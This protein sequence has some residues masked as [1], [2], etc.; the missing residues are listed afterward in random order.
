MFLERSG[1]REEKRRL[2]KKK[3]K[4]TTGGKI[5]EVKQVLEM[6][7]I[8]RDECWRMPGD[9]D[10]CCPRW[11]TTSSGITCTNTTSYPTVPE[12]GC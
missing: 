11:V 2:R 9:L 7:K 5:S 6:R 3:M 4:M 12:R 8:R 1:L 10:Q